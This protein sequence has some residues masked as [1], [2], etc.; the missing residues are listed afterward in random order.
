MA[1]T[2]T[3][4]VEPRSLDEESSVRFWEARR[5]PSLGPLT[6]AAIQAACATV[7]ALSSLRTPLGCSSL[8]AA[9]A[10]GPTTGFHANNASSR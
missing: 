7:V 8:V 4:E 2:R 9:T 10:A 6:L 3:Q 1:P 5:L